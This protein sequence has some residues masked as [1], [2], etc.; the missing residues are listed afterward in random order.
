MA[1]R[2]L[3]VDILSPPPHTLLLLLLLPLL[4]LLCISLPSACALL[5]TT[6]TTHTL[7]WGPEAIDLWHIQ[8]GDTV[9]W[10]WALP[11]PFNCNL[12]INNYNNPTSNMLATTDQ[13]EVVGEKEFYSNPHSYS[14]TF[15][16]AGVFSCSCTSKQL[17]IKSTIVVLKG[18]YFICNIYI[19]MCVCLFIIVV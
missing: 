8:Q 5:P 9:Q 13:Q 15:H 17:S 4:T 14:F 3:R 10:I 7:H 16:H 1:R 2:P 19:Y 12:L 18:V 11:P 6:T